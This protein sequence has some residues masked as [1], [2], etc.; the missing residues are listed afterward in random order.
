MKNKKTRISDL[1]KVRRTS[2]KKMKQLEEFQ[3][4]APRELDRLRRLQST[5]STTLSTFFYFGMKNKTMVR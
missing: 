2:K 4:R 3:I 5:P 1:E